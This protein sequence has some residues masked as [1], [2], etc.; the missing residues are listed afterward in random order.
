MIPQSYE[1]RVQGGL[2]P[3]LRTAFQPLHTW[4]EDDGRVTVLS[5]V[6]SDQSEL[7]GILDAIDGLGLV[8]VEVRPSD[9][10]ADRPRAP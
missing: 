7:T 9:A 3:S 6:I 8:L 4:T 2:T 1:F 10:D 5:G